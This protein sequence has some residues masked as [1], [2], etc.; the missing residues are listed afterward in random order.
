MKFEMPHNYRDMGPVKGLPLNWRDEVTGI[1]PAA[2]KAYLDHCVDGA[3]LDE[4]QLEIVRA[5]M[6]HYINAPCW[7]WAVE[8]DEEM[9]LELAG[10]RLDVAFLKT[11]E[12][13]GAWISRCLDIG[14]DPL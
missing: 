7:N 12:A 6:E 14:I 2:I 9:A 11:S 4:A 10:L 1:L 13:V 5:F 8:A 3:Q